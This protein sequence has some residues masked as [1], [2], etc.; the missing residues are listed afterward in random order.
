MTLY[1][2]RVRRVRRGAGPQAG[3][4]EE[5]MSRGRVLSRWTWCACVCNIADRGR[6]AAR[7]L[8]TGPR[9]ASFYS[10]YLALRGRTHGGCP[11][12]ISAS[13]GRTVAGDF[14][15]PLH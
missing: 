8:F 14:G 9:T 1:L 7:Y 11:R 5:S 2:P 6:L 3:A 10:A 12:A 4:A 13:D 15:L